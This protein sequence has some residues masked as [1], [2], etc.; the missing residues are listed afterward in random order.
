[1]NLQVIVLSLF[2]ALCSPVFAE[3][4]ASSLPRKDSA[5]TPEVEAAVESLIESKKLFGAV[6]LVAQSGK[7]RHLHPQGRRSVRGKALMTSDSIFRIHSMTK[8]IVSAA[9]L[10]QLEKGKYQLSD[11]VSRFIPEFEKLTVLSAD[12]KPKPAKKVMT[13]EDLFRHTSGLSYGFTA[14]PALEKYYE[15]ADFWSGDWD[16]FMGVLTKIPL[17][18][19]PGESWNYGLSTDVLGRLVEIWSGQSLDQYLQEHIFNPLKMKD[20]GFWIRNETDAKRMVTMQFSTPDGLKAAGDQALKKAM[21]KPSIMSGGGGLYSTAGDYYQFLQMIADGGTRNGDQFLKPETVALMTSDQL[22]EKVKNIFF[23]KEQ[24]LGTGF[25]LG[26]SVVTSDTAGWDDVAR[27]GEFGWGGA[28]SCHYWV[29][30]VDENLIVITLEQT[31]PYN[32]N[33]ERALK[34]VIYSAIRK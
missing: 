4:S 1:M 18:H 6:T 25:G 8:A 29:S 27:P 15:G 19:E 26:F 20:T 31:M 33:L 2:V 28:A 13:I 17:V 10:Q 5:I 22:P 32:W 3:S 9:A 21:K 23:G 30:P 34:P 11:P 16:Q 14:P 7:I 12:G 24:R